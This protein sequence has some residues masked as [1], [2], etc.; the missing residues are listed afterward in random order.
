MFKLCL[1]NFLVVSRIHS[2]SEV[3]VQSHWAQFMI[4]TE[5]FGGVIIKS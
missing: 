2:F 1:G 3:S 5:F 4:I